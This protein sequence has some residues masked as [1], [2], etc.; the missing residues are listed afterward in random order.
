[1][2]EKADGEITTSQTDR[3]RASPNATTSPSVANKSSSAPLPSQHIIP[4]ESKFGPVRTQKT[5]SAGY[6]VEVHLEHVRAQL[7]VFKHIVAQFEDK[8]LGHA[9]VIDLRMH[10]PIYYWN[11][12]AATQLDARLLAKRVGLTFPEP[13]DTTHAIRQKLKWVLSSP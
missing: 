5:A 9:S 4:F 7:A 8:V 6:A 11:N 2:S 10:D 3:D 1:M 12:I 13:D